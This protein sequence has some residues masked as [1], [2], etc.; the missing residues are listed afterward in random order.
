MALSDTEGL[1]HDTRSLSDLG[2]GS[3]VVIYPPQVS[4]IHQVFGQL[5][6]EK[7]TATQN[8]V[9][10]YEAAQAAG[11]AAIQVDGRFV[12]EPVYKRAR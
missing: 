5:G 6:P 3:R 7:L 9:A 1:R 10:M 12:D 4:V 8:V 11:S 2:N